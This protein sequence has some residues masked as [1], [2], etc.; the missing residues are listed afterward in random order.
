MPAILVPHEQLDAHRLLPRLW[1]GSYPPERDFLQKNGFH[2]LALCAKELQTPYAFDGLSI[3][4][5]PLHDAELT[6]REIDLASRAA[7][8]MTSS[9]R[10]GNRLLITCAAGRNRSGL[11]S[12]LTIRQLLD[13]SGQDAANQVRLHR[14]NALTN[15]SFMGY[16]AA[17]GKPSEEK[18][19]PRG[20][21]AA[22]P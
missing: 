6:S 1:Q 5:C 11:V 22:R 20:R 13:C 17:L 8:R 19:R 16:L 18:K 21:A 3:Y 14:P 10:A 4:L 7:D 2:V 9:W 12:A 15:P